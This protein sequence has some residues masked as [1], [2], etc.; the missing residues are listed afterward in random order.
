MKSTI[1]PRLAIF[2]LSLS[3]SGESQ[4]CSRFVLSAEGQTPCIKV[5][6]RSRLHAVWWNSGRISYG[7]FDSLGMPIRSVQTIS[8][9]GFTENPRIAVGKD[10]A[11]A[12]WRRL[13]LTFSSDIV[14]QIISK[15]GCPISGNFILND[16]YGDA[17]RFSPDANY[18]NDSTFF[19]VWSGN[20]P[21]TPSPA[22]GVYG[23]IVSNSLHFYGNNQ[24]LNDGNLAD[25]ADYARISSDMESKTAVVVWMNSN[26]WGN[27]ILGR[28]FYKDGS[29]V[30]LPF[31]VD[32]D[33]NTIH[34]WS[35]AVVMKRDGEFIVAWSAQQAGE[36][37]AIF[38]RCFH[39]DGDPMGASKRISQYKVGDVAAV[40]IAVDRGGAAIVVW[41]GQQNNRTLIA[42]QRIAPDGR[43]IGGNFDIGVGAD[44]ANQYSPSIDL[45]DGSIYT[46]WQESGA[47]WASMLDFEHPITQ[48]RKKRAVHPG[49]WGLYRSYPNPFY[50]TTKIEYQLLRPSRVRIAIYDCRGNEVI[51]LVEGDMPEGIHG[52][53]WN[54]KNTFGLYVSS[55]IYFCRF[56]VNGYDKILKIIFVR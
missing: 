35:P 28:I 13:S 10:H 12:I 47:I 24:L 6:G 38:Y 43:P 26:S 31:W 37:W 20:G 54:G 11:I 53:E 39:A 27:K 41:E 51:K 52:A 49:V 32:N 25:S 1:L 29:P 16:P 44:T 45:H 2:C 42:A 8:N 4:I 40:D 34:V 56:S 15:D 33:L 46:A 5:D 3:K 30:G 7:L 23:Q 9:G 22:T 48:V 55:G 50:S 18:L 21:Q 19:A 36:H 17:V 14:G